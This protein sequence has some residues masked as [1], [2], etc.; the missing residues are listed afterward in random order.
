MRSKPGQC[1]QDMGP[2]AAWGS[3][4]AKQGHVPACECPSFQEF[5]F[6]KEQIPGT[7]ARFAKHYDVHFNVLL[8]G[9]RWVGSF[10]CFANQHLPTDEDHWLFSCTCNHVVFHI[11]SCLMVDLS[12]MQCNETLEKPA[13]GDVVKNPSCGPYSAKLQPVRDATWHPQAND[14]KGHVLIYTSEN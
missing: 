5:L 14:V 11:V 7:Q 1:V 2:L 4:D 6:Q 3:S 12:K 13:Y 8:C 9:T 10:P